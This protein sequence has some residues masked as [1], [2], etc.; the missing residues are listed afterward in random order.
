MLVNQHWSIL[1]LV[2]CII[3][4]GFCKHCVDRYWKKI[5]MFVH[6]CRCTKDLRRPIGVRALLAIVISLDSMKHIHFHA[7]NRGKISPP[8]LCSI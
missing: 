1:Y 2:G 8:A 5:L 7:I 3:D 6:H 4:P